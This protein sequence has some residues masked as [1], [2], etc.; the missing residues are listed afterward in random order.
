M[1]SE[2]IIK[3]ELKAL[4][5]NL[6]VLVGETQRIINNKTETSE[7]EN[8]R[9]QGFLLLGKDTLDNLLRFSDRIGINLKND[10]LQKDDDA[11]ESK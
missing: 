10:A 3:M 5:E 7:F 2:Q 11:G 9:Q 1:K 6:V 4:M 8:G